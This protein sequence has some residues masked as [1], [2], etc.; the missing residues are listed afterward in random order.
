MGTQIEAKPRP[1]TCSP[2]IKTINN[3][4]KREIDPRHEIGLFLGI[5]EFMVEI[6]NRWW[7]CGNQKLLIP[8]DASSSRRLARSSR[9]RWIG[10]GIREEERWTQWTRR[11][12]GENR[13][14]L[15]QTHAHTPSG[16]SRGP[17]SST[18]IQSNH[19]KRHK[20]RILEERSNSKPNG[21]MERLK[22]SRLLEL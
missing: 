19:K 4:P 2:W 20:G 10:E 7:I 12:R 18:Q 1:T 14:G 13:E 17:E 22:R 8:Y 9:I 16:Y 3:S 21:R 11:T 5:F 6:T 15:I